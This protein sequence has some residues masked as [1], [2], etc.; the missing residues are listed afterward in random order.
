MV[1]GVQHQQWWML[2][3][4]K[5]VSHVIHV[6]G[7]C[8]EVHTHIHTHKE[9]YF[10]FIVNA[11]KRRNRKGSKNTCTVRT[12]QYIIIISI[13]RSMALSALCAGHT[14]TQSYAALYKII[15]EVVVGWWLQITNMWV[16]YIMVLGSFY[17]FI[18]K[19]PFQRTGR[20]LIAMHSSST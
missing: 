17:T 18:I 12:V 4:E 14:R 9:H 1:G 19:L 16:C 11:T 8:M 10:P 2:P 3:L 7:A 13:N 5:Q 20:M 6:N 15:N